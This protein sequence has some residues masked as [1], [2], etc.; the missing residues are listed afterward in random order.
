MKKILALMCAFALVSCTS[1]NSAVT[2]AEPE[3]PT[4]ITQM[5]D[6]QFPTEWE[7]KRWITKAS[8]LFNNGRPILSA[9]RL[10]ELAKL[11]T[12]EIFKK[13]EASDRFGDFVLD[14]NLYFLGVRPTSIRDGAGYVRDDAVLYPSAMTSAKEVIKNGDFFKLLAFQQPIYAHALEDPEKYKKGDD[15]EALR[16]NILDKI[17]EML[18]KGTA[19]V[20]DGLPK[21]K[22]AF[23]D[24]M[25]NSSP[26]VYELLR[27]AGIP[28]NLAYHV[29]LAPTS[30]FFFA[31]FGYCFG[32][33]SDDLLEVLLY[34]DSRAAFDNMLKQFQSLMPENY[35]DRSLEGFRVFDFAPML[36]PGTQS[37]QLSPFFWDDLPNSST[38]MNRKRGAYMLKHF[39]CDDL[40]PINVELPDDHTQIHGS[41]ASCYSCHYKLDP[42]A[43][44]F[45]NTGTAGVDF[46][47]SPIIVFSDNVVTNREKY[48]ENW[49]STKA[50]RMWNVGL[51]RSSTRENLNIYGQSYEDLF[52]I[53]QDAPEVKKCIVRK[54][55][56][57][58]LGERQSVDSGY[59]DYLFKTFT[60]N[61]KVNSSQAFKALFYTLATSQTFVSGDRQANNCYDYAPGASPEGRPPCQVAYVFQQQCA[62]CHGSTAGAGN[63]DL[64]HWIKTEGEKMSFPHLDEK[65]KQIPK[66]ETLKRIRE[67]LVEL[68]PDLRMPYKRHIPHEDLEILMKWLETEK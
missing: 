39:F 37:T 16:K 8:M 18:D 67:R 1:E 58:T 30:K 32:G 7:K 41:E 3:K 48:L 66:G 49:K 40:T 53:I 52:R 51:V 4:V 5:T 43:G 60:E 56:Q 46:S 31:T 15:R 62:T 63:L 38:N 45:R 47:L 12:S 25:T 13:L 19:Y 9:K 17:V 44:F 33:G 10:G 36:Q 68:D 54:A 42:M 2:T 35:P 50:Q 26:G 34:N 27:E 11:P 59:V 23:C 6:I 24:V 61:A 20:A 65:Q 14:F 29:A 21:N 57:Y 28:K 64:V 55:I 22:K